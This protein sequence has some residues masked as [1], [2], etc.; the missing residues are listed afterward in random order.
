MRHALGMARLIGMIANR[1]DLCNRFAEFEG[2]SLGARR[3]NQAWGWGVGFFQSGDI[4][5]KRR[6]IDERRN[7]DAAY[8]LAELRSD[9]ML[10]QVRRATVGGAQ[11]NN[12]HPFRYRQWLFASTGTV[13]GDNTADTV[14]KLHGSLPDF[15]QRSVRGETDSEVFF[16]LFLSFLHD[17]GQLHQETVA[18]T[19]IFAALQSALGLLDRITAGSRSSMN[20]LVATPEHLIAVCRGKKMGRRLLAGRD[21][22]EP[23]FSLSGASRLTMPDLEP[24]RLGVVA[25]NFEGDELPSQWTEIPCGSMVAF[26]RTGEPVVF[27]P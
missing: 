17:N 6:P 16:H 20:I 26:S 15:L 14:A 24:C 12:A 23:M 22:F 27:Q 13:A 8:M 7:I 21:D 19:A 18:P 1:P 25:S 2:S 4:L 5:L 9:L 10:A 11:T 3:G